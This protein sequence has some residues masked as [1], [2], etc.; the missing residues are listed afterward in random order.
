[1]QVLEGD[2]FRSLQSILLEGRNFETCSSDSLCSL[3]EKIMN[4]KE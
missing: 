3:N 1:M 4:K 2:D